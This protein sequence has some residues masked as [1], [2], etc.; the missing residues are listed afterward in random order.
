MRNLI[1]DSIVFFHSTK[2]K[3]FLYSSSQ[4]FI[5]CFFANSRILG[6]NSVSLLKYFSTGKVL[7]GISNTGISLLIDEK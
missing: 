3:M 7:Q 2:T 4:S 5:L 6:K 1:V